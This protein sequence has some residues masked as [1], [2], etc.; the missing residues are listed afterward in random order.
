MGQNGG[1]Q[2][3]AKLTG[4]VTF[5]GISGCLD[6]GDGGGQATVF[7]G[8]TEEERPEGVSE[9]EFVSGPVPP[10]YREAES[11]GGETRDPDAL[12]SKDAAKFQEASDAVEAGLADPDQSCI[13]C[14]E[15]IPDKNGDG[16]GACAK[17]EGYIGPEDWCA[18][19]ESLGEHE[20][21]EYRNSRE[22]LR[23]T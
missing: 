6:G 4:I 15:F 22:W 9:A 21:K 20:A 11:I 3:S 23:R 2:R 14:S 19:W 18:L 12:T 7:K 16:F 1:R 5:V 8:E 10:A 13:N 17:V